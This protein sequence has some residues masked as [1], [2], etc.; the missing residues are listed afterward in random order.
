[1]SRWRERLS[2]WESRLEERFDDDEEDLCLVL[3][4]DSL[5]DD[6]DEEDAYLLLLLRGTSRTFRVRLVVGSRTDACAG[7]WDT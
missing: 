3:R 7:S 1:M 4:D 6:D 2:R 5:L